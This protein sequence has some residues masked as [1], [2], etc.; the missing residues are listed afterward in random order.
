M[1]NKIISSADKNRALQSAIIAESIV[2][3]DAKEQDV[4]KVAKV[5]YAA[6][7]RL[8]GGLLSPIYAG[9]LENRPEIVANREDTR[10]K[11]VMA[12][13]ATTIAESIVGSKASE[14]DTEKVAKILYKV[15]SSQK[16]SILDPIY[17]TL[18][19]NRPEITAEDKF[20]T[21]KLPDSE[22][23]S[24]GK[25]ASSEGSPPYGTEEG[26][27]P[28]I[29]GDQPVHVHQGRPDA[30]VIDVITHENDPQTNIKACRSAE[31]RIVRIH[32][33]ALD[34]KDIKSEEVTAAMKALFAQV[35]EEPVV[36]TI[37]KKAQDSRLKSDKKGFTASLKAAKKAVEI[38]RAG[39]NLLTEMDIDPTIPSGWIKDLQKTAAVELPQEGKVDEN[40]TD[41]EV[42][43]AVNDGDD[44]DPKLPL[45]NGVDDK[46]PNADPGLDDKDPNADPGL[47][48]DQDID[49]KDNKDPDGLDDD[50]SLLDDDGDY[51][52]DHVMDDDDNLDIDDGNLSGIDVAINDSA[53]DGGTH[54]EKG[55]EVSDGDDSEFFGQENPDKERGKLRSSMRLPRGTV[56]ASS[57]GDGLDSLFGV[58][59][60]DIDEVNKTLE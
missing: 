47:D 36:A 27:D 29:G 15:E 12:G 7:N 54:E 30:Q 37:I 34:G 25:S 41:K 32:N 53:P 57:A 40:E 19:S 52:S 23:F 18:A 28:K 11:S 56:T 5:L 55:H 2:G 38:V 31:R 35:E 24:E 33:A 9:L 4:E 39:F 50:D 1:R 21:L 49:E 58:T 46:D 8:Q 13:K 42:T 14:E 60:K 45:G 22:K 48:D 16:E 17:A 59:A 6:E 44:Q 10:D 51:D 20:T 43:A 26:K 3:E